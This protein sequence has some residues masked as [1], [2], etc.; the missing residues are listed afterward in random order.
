MSVVDKHPGP[1]TTITVGESNPG[2]GGDTRYY[3]QDNR[4]VVSIFVPPGV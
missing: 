4:T 1:N 3:V 2:Y